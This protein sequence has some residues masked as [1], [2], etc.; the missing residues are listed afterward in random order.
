M[1]KIFLVVTIALLLLSSMASA[2]LWD[3]GGGLIYDD[4]LDVTWLQ[5][6]DYAVTS[7][8]WDSPYPDDWHFTEAEYETGMMIWYEAMAW[9]ESLEYYDSVRNI[10]WDN[11]RLPSVYDQD[12]N[13][14]DDVEYDITSSEMG[15]MYYNNLSGTT[16]GP[17]PNPSFVDGTNTSVTIIN[18][19]NDQYHT[20]WQSPPATHM[21]PFNYDNGSITLD[22]SDRPTSYAWAVR[23]GDVALPE[24]PTVPEP[25]TML[26][27]GTGLLG[28]A[29]ARRRMKK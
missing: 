5:D 3:R 19:K 10:T 9:A 6:A 26:L 1:R 22:G 15:H 23:D 14:P 13:H 7:G 2:T 11:W 27:L 16:G 21:H 8:Y 18:L 4:V 20:S 28:L 24:L 12:G 29:G 25:T 17:M